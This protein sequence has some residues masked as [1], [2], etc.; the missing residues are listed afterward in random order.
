MD[1]NE[2]GTAQ[3]LR[4]PQTMRAFREMKLLTGGYLA[5]S[6]LT[7]GAVYLLRD[8][9]SVV[10]D[11]VWVRGGI[12]AL[13]SLL[14]FALA[15]RAAGGSRGAYRRLRILSAVMVVAVVVIVS[16]P[17]FLPPWMRIEQAVCGLLLLRVVVITAGG[18]MRALFAAK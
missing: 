3:D 10:N 9:P 5:L 13:A 1:E 2:N 4:H 18:R 14:S 11:N 15:R 12:V 16:L 6:W 8:H 7:M 17:R